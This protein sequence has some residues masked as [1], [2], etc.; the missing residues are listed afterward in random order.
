MKRTFLAIVA[1]LLMATTMNA[2]RLTDVR[3]EARFITDMMTM[4][5]GLDD[6]QR[7]GV[8]ALNL[9]YLDGINSYRDIDARGW[10]HRNARMKSL[11]D[12]RQWRMFKDCDYFYRPIGWRD[13]AYV[14]HIYRKYPRNG[15]PMPPLGPDKRTH[16][17]PRPDCAFGKPERP[18]LCAGKREFDNNSPEAIKMRQDMRRGNRF[19]R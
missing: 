5:L 1:T 15:R 12:S 14:H 6:A 8:M 7:D 13:N 11:L 9:A 18:N 3:A 16:K 19:A 17:N 4:E 10:K 2:Q